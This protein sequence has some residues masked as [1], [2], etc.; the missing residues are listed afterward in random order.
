MRAGTLV[1]LRDSAMLSVGW[2]PT[3]RYGIVLGTS[4]S[5]F[6]GDQDEMIDLIIVMSDGYVEN[7]YE[8]DL[9]MIRGR[10]G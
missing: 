10:N 8:D 4:E 1:K 6:K 2:E 9:I 3:E 7:F 5:V